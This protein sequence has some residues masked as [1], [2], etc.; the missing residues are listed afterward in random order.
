MFIKVSI[1][2][3]LLID[4]E[5]LN[6]NY[7]ELVDKKIKE[8]YL[9]K[10]IDG[11]GLCVKI[12][13]YSSR[14]AKICIGSANLAVEINLVCLVFS[15]FEGEILQAQISHQDSTGLVARLFSLSVFIPGQNLHPGS[16]FTEDGQWVWKYDD[17][18]YAF[19]VGDD[20]YF[21]TAN[22]NFNSRPVNNS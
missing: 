6:G 21:K 18:Q 16:Y 9:L 3:T 13:Q 5:E 20:V 1:Q 15:S 19:N 22:V 17:S 7:G 14:E 10:I 11:Q 8:K 4:P 12:A 2:D